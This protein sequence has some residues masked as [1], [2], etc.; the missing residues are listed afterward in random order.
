MLLPVTAKRKEAAEST[1][2]TERNEKLPRLQEDNNLFSK[3]EKYGKTLRA[4]KPLKPQAATTQPVTEQASASKTTTAQQLSQQPAEQAT[5]SQ[6]ATAQQLS[7]Q[8]AEQAANQTAT[9]QQLSQ[10]LAEQATASQTAAAQQLKQINKHLQ[11]MRSKLQQL[12]TIPAETQWTLLSTS[13]ELLSARQE[14]MMTDL[15]IIRDRIINA[16]V[17]H[18]DV[19][20]R[21]DSDNDDDL[22]GPI[23]PEE[24]C[25]LGTPLCHCREDDSHQ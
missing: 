19:N 2:V 12:T 6:T 21:D 18:G 17:N 24:S 15:N 9:A 1:T 8:L 25:Y 7:Q 3:M 14:I 13:M 22:W 16:P 11:E 4:L 23:T 20:D 10:Q 5:A